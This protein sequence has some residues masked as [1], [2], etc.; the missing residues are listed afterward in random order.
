ML[1]ALWSG[2]PAL[3]ADGLLLDLGVSS[4]QLDEASRG[5]SFQKDGPLDMRMGE[6]G[7][8]AA[9]LHSIQ[10]AESAFRSGGLDLRGLVGSVAT[11]RTFRYRTPA[12]GE[13]LP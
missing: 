12:A 4:P 7:D 9:D 13:V 2:S 3:P 1:A 11:T 10:S 6:A 8:T 5:F